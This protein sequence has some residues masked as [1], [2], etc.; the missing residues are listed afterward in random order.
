MVVVALGKNLLFK[1]VLVHCELESYIKSVI[2]LL[3]EAKCTNTQ[4]YILNENMK[5][6]WK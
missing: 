5:I 3:D 6:V 2:V 1:S 4:T